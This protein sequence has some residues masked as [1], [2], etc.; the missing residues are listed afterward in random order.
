MSLVVG[1]NKCRKCG[2]SGHNAVTCGKPTQPPIAELIEAS[3]SIRSKKVV[4]GKWDLSKEEE[5]DLAHRWIEKKDQQAL[6]MLVMS[7]SGLA[8]KYASKYRGF[9]PIKDLCQ[10]A[11]LGLLEAAHRFDPD[12][13]FRLSTYAHWWIK[14][15]IIDYV[16]RTNGIIRIGTTRSQRKVIFGLRSTT[17]KIEAE[18]N[19]PSIKAIAKAL[20]VDEKTVELVVSRMD[21]PDIS[22]GTYVGV[23]I[24]EDLIGENATQESGYIEK[25]TAKN[26]RDSIRR[27]MVCLDP[28]ERRVIQQR[29][30]IDNPK[31]LS[32]LGCIFG[33]SKE[34]VRQLQDRA[35]LKIKHFLEGSLEDYTA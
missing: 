1:A 23:G 25:E 28:R 9:A 16:I 35:L 3:P 19:I 30:L 10:E 7:Y 4:Y 22:L 33:I 29:F 6:D 8:K 21:T 13:D 12:R 26:I 2:G 18:G 24:V 11:M 31:T 20:E 14:A 27:S 32:E 5:K 17:A 15:Y 34:R